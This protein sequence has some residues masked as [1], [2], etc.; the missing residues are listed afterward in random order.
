MEFEEITHTNV[1]ILPKQ[2]GPKLVWYLAKKT[3]ALIR[4]KFWLVLLC[5][6][7]AFAGTFVVNEILTPLYEA[8]GDYVLELP[9]ATNNMFTAVSVLDET[10]MAGR[11]LTA[12]TAS[13][14]LNRLNDD[15]TLAAVLKAELIATPEPQNRFAEAIRAKYDAG[16]RRFTVSAR[17]PNP[18]LARTL[19]ERLISS[20]NGTLPPR[21]ALINASE[22][23]KKRRFAALSRF[24]NDDPM[25][26]Q[27][28]LQPGSLETV[29]ARTETAP[30]WTPQT[31]TPPTIVSV[32]PPADGKDPAAP[33]TELKSQIANVSARIS[34]LQRSLSHP[35]AAGLASVGGSVRS[36]YQAVAAARAKLQ[37]ATSHYQIPPDEKRKMEGVIASSQSRFVQAVRNQLAAEQA[38]KIELEARRDSLVT[39]LGTSD[40]PEQAEIAVAPLAT[41]GI[42]TQTSAPPQHS[43]LPQAPDSQ[44]PM[45]EPFD[46][47]SFD[48]MVPLWQSLSSDGASFPSRL[49]ALR[50][51]VSPARPVSPEKTKNLL[52]ALLCGFAAGCVAAAFVGF[53]DEVIT[54]PA[55]IE[56]EFLVP[57]LGLIAK[58]R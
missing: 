16:M 34:A 49:A 29:T 7:T 40:R 2:D 23:I 22:A 10:A 1:V 17:D 26:A 50:E 21:D 58:T 48:A 38:Q 24:K 14:T 20:Y 13:S 56:R 36:A 55:D 6:S 52:L 35:S 37:N 54:S 4:K 41:D 45:A 33:L 8:S 3:V 46:E 47:S 19:I 57:V 31:L 30:T 5:M 25:P 12:L 11:V 42:P 51:P 27:T 39:A 9:Q 53:Q 43:V 32:S 15:E 44:T 18:D 28:S